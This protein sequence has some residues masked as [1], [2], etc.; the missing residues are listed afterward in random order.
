MSLM[1]GI[2]GKSGSID[3][4]LIQLALEEFKLAD[5]R[6]V[7]SFSA[8]GFYLATAE[9][10]GLN[11]T[12]FQDE[13]T[14]GSIQ[15][16][17][18]GSK[19]SLNHI[20][21]DHLVQAVGNTEGVFAGVFY[22]KPNHRLFIFNDK[23]GIQPLFILNLD[24]VFCFCSEYEP[25]LRFFKAK[26]YLDK[27]AIA[28]F[29]TVGLPLGTRTF[30]TN[31]N[32]VGPARLL[33]IERDHFNELSYWSPK[34]GIDLHLSIE[35][36]AHRISNVFKEVINEYIDHHSDVMCLLSAGADSRLILSALSLENRKKLKF[37]TSLLPQLNET[38]DR[39]VIGATSLAQHLNLHHS[40]TKVSDYDIEFGVDYFDRERA[41]RPHKLVGGWHGGEILGGCCIFLLIVAFHHFNRL[42]Y[43]TENATSFL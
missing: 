39:D 43:F 17:L 34:I 14:I 3:A 31:I 24:D 36:H 8:P 37:L 25:L 19:E 7:N 27:T 2:Y 21:T 30:L 11:I 5:S 38:Q 22:Q 12:A 40:I 35:D 29:F 28:Q 20:S 13:E 41:L 9:E 42:E 26:H 15:G 6:I 1:L 32:K 4:S 23:F 16:H 10:G 33:T 18:K